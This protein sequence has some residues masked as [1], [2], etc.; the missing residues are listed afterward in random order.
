M[1]KIKKFRLPQVG[2]RY[3]PILSQD[4]E[5]YYSK[6]R[7]H[8][9]FYNTDKDALCYAEMIAESLEVSLAEIDN[10]FEDIH[11]INELD[12]LAAAI[13]SSAWIKDLHIK[14]SKYKRNPQR[15]KQEFE[16]SQNEY[17][18]LCNLYG[19]NPKKFDY[20]NRHLKYFD[21]QLKIQKDITY[22]ALLGDCDTSITRAEQL[23]KLL[24]LIKPN[25]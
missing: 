14:P 9:L 11:N 25:S 15:A 19:F 4:Q 12:L 17:F 10:Y 1:A 7:E 22:D 2:K 24:D 18:K 6:R 8:V 5:K 21:E 13:Q 3:V 16:K 23:I 20:D